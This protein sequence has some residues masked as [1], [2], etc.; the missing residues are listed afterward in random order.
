MDT[1]VLSSPTTDLPDEALDVATAA[2]EFAVT[3]KTI[4]KHI[5]AGSLPAVNYLGKMWVSRADAKAIFTPRPVPVKA[6]V[7]NA[8]TPETD[9]ESRNRRAALLGGGGR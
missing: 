3:A 1:T 7:P 2:H 8:I 5:H 9:P 4:R 6:S